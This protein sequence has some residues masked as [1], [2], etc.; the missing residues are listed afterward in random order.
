MN[1]REDNAV[2]YVTGL[3]II[4]YC[5]VT[6]IKRNDGRL[7]LSGISTSKKGRRRKLFR[8]NL[9]T[10][11]VETFFRLVSI[12]VLTGPILFGNISIR[13]VYTTI[14][15]GIFD[16]VKKFVY[17]VH[18]VM[19]D[20]D[21]QHFQDKTICSGQFKVFKSPSLYSTHQNGSEKNIKFLYLTRSKKLLA[22]KIF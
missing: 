14:N 2:L 8:F 22:Y 6:N 18:N 10:T 4:M 5:V 21:R 17:L 15:L 1:P 9:V 19:R 13:L 16:T 12:K 20:I 11:V 7:L 3:F